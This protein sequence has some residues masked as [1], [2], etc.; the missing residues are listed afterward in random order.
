MTINV[1]QPA[2]ILLSPE[3]AGSL[4]T[5]PMTMDEERRAIFWQSQAR[6]YRMGKHGER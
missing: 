5:E 2:I 3:E 1:T 6:V 4:L